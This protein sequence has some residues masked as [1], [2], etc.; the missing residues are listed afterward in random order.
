MPI[1][2]LLGAGSLLGFGASWFVSDTTDKL[3]KLT[4]IGGVAYFLLFTSS[5][6][7]LVKKVL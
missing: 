5:G 3:I 2:L 4:V 1:F 6:Q 7:K